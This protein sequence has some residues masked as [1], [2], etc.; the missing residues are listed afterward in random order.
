MSS[1]GSLRV[2]MVGYAFMGAAHSHAWRSAHRFF[3]LPLVPEL[4][5][6]AGRNVLWNATARA[7]K[8]NQMGLLGFGGD[9]N[10]NYRVK[11][12]ASAAIF[13]ND[14]VAVGAEYR[15]KPDNLSVFKEDNFKDVFIAYA[16]NKL[17]AI[18][19]AYA[20]LGN[21]ANQP[22]QH[23]LYVSGQFSF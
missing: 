23:G 7:T 1:S 11:L 12:E 8:A 17:F 3:D 15:S 19:A 2:G 9:K 6:L 18:T 5:A 22:N 4:T 20:W 13:V 10:D 21:I 16:P 14:R